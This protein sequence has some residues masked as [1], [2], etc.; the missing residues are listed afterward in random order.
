MCYNAL[1]YQQDGY[2]NRLEYQKRFAELQGETVVK[3]FLYDDQKHLPPRLKR[4]F[5]ILNA[6]TKQDRLVLGIIGDEID[7]ENWFV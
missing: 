6:M 3:P 5:A 7:N 4:L 2:M 1:D